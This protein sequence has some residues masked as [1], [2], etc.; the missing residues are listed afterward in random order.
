M[1]TLIRN[2]EQ[3]IQTED[4][5]RQVVKGEEMSQLPSIDNAFLVMHDDRIADFGPMD[6]SPEDGDIVVNANGKYVL[7]AWCDSHTHLV[8]A[9]SREQ[10]FVDRIRGLSYEEIAN[11]GGGILNSAEL[12]RETSE[13]TLLEQAL[14]RAN[15]IM[16]YGTGAVEIKSG[17]GLTVESELKMLRVIRR[18]KDM[19]SLTIKSTFL[20]AHA[21][22]AEYKNNRGKYVDMVV[23]E[24]MPAVKE[25]KLA[26]YCDVFCEKMAFTE[27]ETKRIF[28]AANDHGLQPKLHV[29]QFNQ[30]GGIPVAVEQNAISVDHLE[31]VSDTDV[32]ALQNASTIPCLLPSVSFFLSIPYAPARKLIDSNLPVALGTDYNP[33]S[34][35]SG[36][37]PFVLSLACL[38]MNMLPEEAIHAA[39]I[40][41]ARA[42][43]LEHETGSIAKGKKANII[44]TKEMSSLPFLPYA[45]GSNMI[46]SV[47]V[48]GKMQ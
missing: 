33:G 11:R 30:T 17:Y 31:Y 9:G 10:E 22:P 28:Q 37:I 12:L 38:K 35:P 21:I 23:K 2:I 46:E 34:S 40:N 19:T 20:G 15:E 43:H 1:K 24:M 25:E 27:N 7:P 36:N 26:D 16:S 14:A 44:I 42:M 47:F 3:L 5:P 41:G 8:Y 6:R 18:L 39:T 4:E 45:F 48:N 29:N 32:A 13:D